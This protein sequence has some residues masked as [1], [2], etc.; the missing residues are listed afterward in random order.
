MKI[1]NISQQMGIK[2]QNWIQIGLITNFIKIFK[3]FTK[4]MNIYRY[5][6]FYTSKIPGGI[7]GR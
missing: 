6:Y 5:L 2:E 7:V 3:K 1:L 4:I